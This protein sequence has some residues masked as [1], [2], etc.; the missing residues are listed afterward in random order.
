[1]L[2]LNDLSLSTMWNYP[3]AKS[4]GEMVDSITAMGFGQIE[5]NY[6]VKGEFI[7]AIEDRIKEGKVRASS[8]HNVFPKVADERFNTDSVLLGFQ[9]EVLRREAVRLSQCS[10]DWAAKLGAKAVVFH[11]TEV[12]L[13]PMAFDRPL[14][15]LISQDKQN[16][17]E[18]RAVF[19]KLLVA[20]QAQP[21]LDALKRSLEELCEYVVQKGYQVYLGMENR[22]MCHQIPIYPEF[23]AI[24]KDFSGSPVKL[25]FDTGHGI[26]MKEIGLQA[27]P[28]R[29]EIQKEIVGVHIHDAA[30]GRDHFPPGMLDGDVLAPYMDI[31]LNAPIK[32][33]ELSSRYP[34]KDIVKG[35]NALIALELLLTQR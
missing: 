14:K 11:P 25:W 17:E 19:Q 10:I 23:E 13:E 27:W 26:M 2:T 34:A 7:P 5:F 8:I 20:R 3:H 4:G 24:M 35:A 28:L 32:V 22:S 29:P 30:K 31:I 15:Y 12:P 9:D 6:Q 1:M 16:T 21:Y 33:L 18:Y